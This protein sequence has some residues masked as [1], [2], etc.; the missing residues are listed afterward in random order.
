ME[1]ESRGLREELESEFQRERSDLID[2]LCY[3]DMN[4]TPDGTP[5]NP[6]DRVNEVGGR[7][8]KDS[9]IGEFIRRAEPEILASTARVLIRLAETKAQPI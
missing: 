1:A 6:V 4:T 7:Y 2:A 8:G 9:L 5:T 3:C